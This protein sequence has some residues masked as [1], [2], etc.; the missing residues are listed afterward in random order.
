MTVGLSSISVDAVYVLLQRHGAPTPP[1]PY[2]DPAGSTLTFAWVDVRIGLATHRDNVDGLDGWEIQRLPATGTLD[3]YVAVIQRTASL[4]TA[5]ATGR[6]AMNASSQE[7]EM[8]AALS[9]AGLP[10][11]CRDLEIRDP[12]SGSVINIP[13]F[14]WVDIKLIVEVDGWFHHHG[15]DLNRLTAAA[16]AGKTV[17]RRG[18]QLRVERDSRKRR[19]LTQLGWTVFVI[20]DTEIDA[21][22]ADRVAAD[23]A[24]M[25]RQLT[26]GLAG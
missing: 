14:A 3:Q 24:S 10:T 11:P 12:D 23:V 9:R 25:H 7:Q 5:A 6:T 8:A 19:I 16:K 21:G 2:R 18:D 4:L 13:D 26:A 17:V 15:R 22:K 20:T 1:Q